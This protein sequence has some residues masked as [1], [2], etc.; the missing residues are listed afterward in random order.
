MHRSVKQIKS[1]AQ[2]WRPIPRAQNTTEIQHFSNNNLI[3]GIKWMEDGMVRNKN[4]IKN[5]FQLVITLPIYCVVALNK[6]L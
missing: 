1:G 6:K 2:H 4:K 3:D 5:I